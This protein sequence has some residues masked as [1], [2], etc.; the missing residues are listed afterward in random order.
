MHIH[1]SLPLHCAAHSSSSCATVNYLVDQCPSS[2][3]ATGKNDMLP[4]HFAARSN[5]NFSVYKT[6]V[7]RSPD[8]IYSR[9]RSGRTALHYAVRH[10]SLA[11]QLVLHMLHI[12]NFNLL[13]MV[14]CN[15][16]SALHYIVRYT[17]NVALLLQVLT[18]C[19]RAI[20][21]APDPEGRLLLH[22]AAAGAANMEMLRCL[23]SS[24]PRT[25]VCTTSLNN[26]DTVYPYE[27][28]P[29]VSDKYIL[30][31][32]MYYSLLGSD[33]TSSTAIGGDSTYVGTNS[34]TAVLRVHIVGDKL[35]GKS[36]V[37]HWLISNSHLLYSANSATNGI[38]G[39][40][41]GMFDSRHYIDMDRG[42]TLGVEIN[43]IH[44]TS[45]TTT[46]STTSTGGSIISTAELPMGSASGNSMG[47][48][49]ATGSNG[50]ATSGD[51]TGSTSTNSTNS[52]NTSINSA[53]SAPP[54]SAPSP[55]VTTT[56]STTTPAPTTVN[57]QFVIY[58]YPSTS[59]ST[60]MSQL[61]QDFLRQTDS[62]YVVVLPMY[63]VEH[64]CRL[65]SSTLVRRLLQTLHAV[66]A[67]YTTHTTCSSA[68]GD[69][70]AHRRAAPLPLLLVVNS[71]HSVL[72]TTETEVRALLA[73]ASREMH[74]HFR[75]SIMDSTSTSTSTSSTT[76]M[77]SDSSSDFLLVTPA[78]IVADLCMK[79]SVHSIAAAVNSCFHHLLHT[80]AST[81]SSVSSRASPMYS[82]YN[83]PSPVYDCSRLETYVYS[84]LSSMNLH[85]YMRESDFVHI[86]YSCIYNYFRQ[87]VDIK[88]L[89]RS[90]AAEDC[91]YNILYTHISRALLT[92]GKIMRYTRSTAACSTSS[93]STT[94]TNASGAM[95]PCSV[96]VDPNSIIVTSPYML[97]LNIFGS[98]L[99]SI[100]TY[101]SS[102]S[103]TS[104]NGGN[105]I[106]R[107]IVSVDMLYNTYY[108]GTSSTSSSMLSSMTLYMLCELLVYL[109]ICIPVLYSSTSSTSSTN[110]TRTAQ[111]ADLEDY[112]NRC[113]S[114]SNSTNGSSYSGNYGRYSTTTSSSSSI[115]N[116]L[117]ND[118]DLYTSGTSSSTTSSSGTVGLWFVALSEIRISDADCAHLY[119]K[120]YTGSSS[121]S[122]NSDDSGS[123]VY[124]HSV[125][126]IVTSLPLD[127]TTSTTS[128]NGS[129]TS[130]VYNRITFTGNSTTTTSTYSP[131]LS[132][133]LVSSVFCRL[134]SIYSSEDLHIYTDAMYA[135]IDS[136]STSTNSNDDSCRLHVLIL[137]IYTTSTST[138]SGDGSS[139]MV[140]LDVH[141]VAEHTSTTTTS[142]T[143]SS[144]SAGDLCRK[145]ASEVVHMIEDICSTSRYANN[146]LYEY[147]STSTGS[148][149][150]SRYISLQ[151]VENDFLATCSDSSSASS[152][153]GRLVR[154]FELLCGYGS[155][156]GSMDMSEVKIS[157]SPLGIYSSSACTNASIDINGITNNSISSTSSSSSSSDTNHVPTG[158]STSS[159]TSSNVSVYSLAKLL[160]SSHVNS[161]EDCQ[162]KLLHVVLHYIRTK[163][164][165]YAYI[166]HTICGTCSSTNSSNDD[167]GTSIYSTS[168][169]SSA[170]SLSQSV[171][172]RFLEAVLLVHRE[173]QQSLCV[174]NSVYNSVY[175]K[176]Q[177]PVVLP[178]LTMLGATST[179]STIYSHLST[180]SCIYSTT[181]SL[182]D[183]S[184]CS[185]YSSSN[186]S[187]IYKYRVDFFCA[188]CGRICTTG[189][190]T[191]SNMLTVVDRPD[192]DVLHVLSTPLLLLEALLKSN[193]YY[194]TSSG[195]TSATP[196]IP[197]SVLT[198]C[199]KL[200]STIEL[201]LSM[202]DTSATSSASAIYEDRERLRRLQRGIFLLTKQFF[203]SIY[204]NSTD[205]ASGIND[206]AN[207][208]ATI[209]NDVVLADVYTTASNTSNSP[210][211]LCDERYYSNVWKFMK[212]IDEDLYAVMGNSMLH[213]HVGDLDA[214]ICRGSSASGSSTSKMSCREVWE[215]RGAGCLAY[216]VDH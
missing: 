154:H 67:L 18:H 126:R 95:V 54:S 196:T 158:T 131:P 100:R 71:F 202:L 42:R 151:S 112:C 121:S 23:L 211:V 176:R 63:N 38:Y 94:T 48:A 105:G 187:T 145:K 27:L 140:G 172:R 119:S 200:Q 22:H 194:S 106:Y 19:P 133:R 110:S 115:Y 57:P 130:N 83:P 26:G 39:S 99:S 101:I 104:S 75:I 73:L 127:G 55:P 208:S 28:A 215:R 29:L 204:T 9:C 107:Y 177:Y 152:E 53:S 96:S 183:S 33:S 213:V 58:D 4:L 162:L 168:T 142:T 143:T 89:K 36:L 74:R 198:L 102:T 37:K 117:Y 207:D 206:D 49:S 5:S 191:S 52:G 109:D 32:Y 201:L 122:S 216:T 72:E 24:Y 161:L 31:L 103:T 137:P 21:L 35:A 195:I 193:Y 13:H 197:L 16:W 15:G 180:N 149:G 90:A 146:I 76:S 188:V 11:E 108:S 45:S 155:T 199:S 184:G 135:L 179:A 147:V 97:G 125:N 50:A 47:S 62:V 2:C 44:N 212:S 60:C 203:S 93:N 78:P 88:R 81:D 192:G 86:I 181:N 141:V 159:S 185:T 171:L 167:Y 160:L 174:Y 129:G 150:N 82:I 3:A 139:C 166:L 79:S 182:Y 134:C 68:H 169:S 148:G 210:R 91:A 8:S 17:G 153:D 34:A 20:L 43:Y 66:H 124:R 136:S 190:T 156:T 113:A 165:S 116:R 214:W 209:Y 1:R 25:S 114:S 189:S 69:A 12:S 92:A 128:I 77:Y 46:I 205:S 14:D 138:S 85:V 111:L 157:L 87:I 64:G 10:A 186:S 164:L 144:S 70:T 132:Q 178:V 80:C 173:M 7:S 41:S 40:A 120:V 59:T 123:M 56:T 30:L 163:E 175:T 98:F 51:S 65:S 6:L 84:M 170:V 61:Q 118:K